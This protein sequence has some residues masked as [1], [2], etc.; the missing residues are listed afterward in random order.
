MNQIFQGALN[1]RI[2]NR[3]FQSLSQ[4]TCGTARPRTFVFLLLLN[5]ALARAESYRA[6]GQYRAALIELRKANQAGIDAQ[7]IAIRQ[8]QLLYDLGQYRGVVAALE[9]VDPG[10]RNADTD[11]MLLKSFISIRKLASAERL[12]AASTQIPKIEEAKAKANIALVRNELESAREQFEQIAAD[13]PNDVDVQLGLASAEASLGD[14]E[15][16]AARISQLVSDHPKHVL[17][18]IAR[19]RLFFD[20][21]QYTEAEDTLSEILIDLPQTDIMQP[22]KSVVLN[23]LVETLTRQG[24]TSEALVYTQSLA[25]ENP[26]SSDLELQFREAM[27][28]WEAGNLEKAFTQFSKIYEQVPSDL[29]GTMLG[30]ISYLQGKPEEAARYFDRHTDP[31]IASAGVLN[32]MSRTL[33]KEGRLNEA[34]A[35]VQKARANAPKN[36]NLKGI[37]GLLMLANGDPAGQSLI[38][39]SLADNPKQRQL[40]IALSRY[41]ASKDDFNAAESYIRSGLKY[42]PEDFDLRRAL[43][44]IKISKGELKAADQQ[45]NE[46]L[47]HNA[48]DTG[49]LLL[50]GDV[51]MLNERWDTAERSYRMG[52]KDVDPNKAKAARAG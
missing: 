47:K 8:A 19:A 23:L 26:G 44:G 16:A 40:W 27:A 29:T 17:A 52:L 49:A 4:T 20:K 46:W 35:A 48:S 1:V 6:Q 22:E 2:T 32:I 15:A 31:E 37:E 34:M 11:I 51:A 33:V 43:I 7:I 14:K 42:F 38:E 30:M 13:H 36:T 3:H 28:S 21:E 50:Q 10:K 39:T 45:I 5:S 24:R 18:R 9:H 25:E 41:T 12:I